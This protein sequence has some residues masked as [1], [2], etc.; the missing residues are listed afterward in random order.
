[1]K[2]NILTWNLNFFYDNWYN[3]IKSINKVLEKEIQNNDIIV[4]QEATLPLIKNIDTIFSYLKSPLVDYTHHYTF[5]DELKI[6]FN[7]ISSWFPE[8]QQEVVSS[9]KFI[10]DKFFN[11]VSWTFYTFGKSF[12]H[13]YFNYK[14]LWFILCFSLLPII[15]ILGYAFLGMI[16]I[17]KKHIQTTVKSKFVGRLFQYCKFKFNKREILF[18]NIH[19][20]EACSK[21]GYNE[22]KKIIKFTENIPHDILI[23]AGDFNSSPR[24]DI[25]KYLV[26][27][28]FKSSVKEIHDRDIK[29]WP[30]NKPESCIDYIWIRGENVKIINAEVFGNSLETDHKGIKCCF[31][32][33]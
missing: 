10:M 9:L 11:I 14:P 19:L 1:M 16:T 2:L 31:D 23:L 22:I 17:T 27:N 4:L 7:K 24:S 3:R 21:K 32:I 26:Q 18:C 25:Y 5:S 13:I 20:N 33:K 15:L 12:Q 30:A 29:T 28:K 6:L 8:K